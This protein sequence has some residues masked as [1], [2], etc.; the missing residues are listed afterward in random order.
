MRELLQ[1]SRLPFSIYT[2]SE[3]ERDRLGRVGGG[4]LLC[5]NLLPP[6]LPVLKIAAALLQRA[7]VEFPSASFSQSSSATVSGTRSQN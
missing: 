1:L 7:F 4:T 5:F 6:Q 3:I 2:M